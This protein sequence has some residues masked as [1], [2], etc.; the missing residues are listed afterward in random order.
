MELLEVG[1]ERQQ[2][3]PNHIVL[4]LLLLLPLLFQYWCAFFLSKKVSSLCSLVTSFFS[5]AML[6]CI[7]WVDGGKKGV[8]FR[9]MRIKGKT[10]LKIVKENLSFVLFERQKR[11]KC[12]KQ[13][14]LKFKGNKI[15]QPPSPP[16]KKKWLTIRNEMK[17]LQMLQIKL[18]RRILLECF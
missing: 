12:I 9:Q 8:L 14:K 11:F 17:R 2:R 10:N 7:S 13:L 6:I 15:D 4:S 5:L 16:P 3:R 18:I 1:E